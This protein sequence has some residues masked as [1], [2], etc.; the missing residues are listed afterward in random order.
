MQPDRPC[1][2]IVHTI[3]QAQGLDG[4]AEA[5]QRAGRSVLGTGSVRRVLSGAPIGHPLHPALVAVP[6]GAWLSASMLD[7]TPGN[8]A[9]ARRLIGFGCLAALPTAVAGT[10]DWLD[11]TGADRRVGLV[12]AGLNDLALTIYLTSWRSRRHGHHASGAVLALAGSGVLAAAG[13]L[14]AHLAYS[15]GVGVTVQHA[16]GA[17]PQPAPE[18]SVE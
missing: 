6:I 17:Y 8:R 1:P 5:I 13:W 4:A 7:L 12:H 15:R 3:E 18:P 2:E 11:T 14:G 16:S 9:A 10:A